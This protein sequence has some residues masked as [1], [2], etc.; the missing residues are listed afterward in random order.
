MDLIKNEFK[1]KLRAKIKED[2]MLWINK[3]GIKKI[4][5]RAIDISKDKNYILMEDIK[6]M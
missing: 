5:K 6:K 3:I 1:M 4:Y 2:Q